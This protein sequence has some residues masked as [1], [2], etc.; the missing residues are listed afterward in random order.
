MAGKNIAYGNETYEGIQMV[1]LP[2]SGGG[3]ASYVETSDADATADDIKSGKTAYVNGAK[4][5]GA[6]VCSGGGGTSGVT[7]LSGTVISNHE[8]PTISGRRMLEV[9]SDGTVYDHYVV[10]LKALN[11][12]V[13]SGEEF[14]EKSGLD[15]SGCTGSVFPCLSALVVYPNVSVGDVTNDQGTYAASEL[16]GTQVRAAVSATGSAEENGASVYA[17]DA[18]KISITSQRN[19]ANNE[20]EIKYAYTVFA[21][22]D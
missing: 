5:T 22:N 8:T 13:K 1:K 12:Y 18:D 11:T 3:N 20:F 17:V 21:W 15:F 14:V 10:L 4:I 19:F 9:P 6:H 7:M 16:K 2:I